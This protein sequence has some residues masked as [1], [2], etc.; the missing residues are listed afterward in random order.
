M[1]RIQEEEEIYIISSYEEDVTIVELQEGEE[2]PIYVPS[3]KKMLLLWDYLWKKAIFLR[4]PLH[5]A[6]KI[7]FC[8]HSL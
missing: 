6:K 5:V 8:V 1:G 7:L 4:E 2:D 3:E